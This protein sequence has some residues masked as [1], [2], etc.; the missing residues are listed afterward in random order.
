MANSARVVFRDDESV[1]A[2]IYYADH[3]DKF[4]SGG[5]ED[6][7]VATACF[8]IAMSSHHHQGYGTY[9][10][11]DPRPQAP[12]HLHKLPKGHGPASS[13]T[14]ITTVN[15]LSSLAHAPAFV[16]A[17]GR[18]DELGRSVSDG[19][20]ADVVGG[21]MEG[22]GVKEGEALTFWKGLQLQGKSKLG[23]PTDIRPPNAVASSSTL[24]ALTT[25]A[26][27][28]TR[29]VVVPREQWFIRRALLAKDAKERER[30]ASGDL[31]PGSTDTT[32]SS[33]PIPR[34]TTP[35]LASLLSI[36]LPPPPRAT[37]SVEGYQPPAYFHLRENNRGWQVLKNIGWD[38]QGGLGRGAGA[39]VA[40][41]KGDEVKQEEGPAERPGLVETSSGRT[42]KGKSRES[43]IDL[44]LDSASSGS[45]SDSDSNPTSNSQRTPEKFGEAFITPAQ[46]SS[47]SSHPLIWSGRTAPIA[48]YLKT[49]LRGI[50]AL[51]ATDRRR[52]LLRPSTLA[53][54]PDHP[55]KR[56]RVTHSA[57]EIRESVRDSKAAGAGLVGEERA[58]WE[59]QKVK[60]DVEVDRRERQRW[61][62]IINRE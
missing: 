26:P 21:A 59:R 35:S 10:D 44:T 17:A 30:Q 49:D 54:P 47:T 40:E 62:E 20:Q 22:S 28:S 48:T 52:T 33:T 57:E 34:P 12:L 39:D 50:G 61:R 24:P 32:S 42:G 58:M 19:V 31:T 9:A 11:T 36:D 14:R 37:D 4:R 2:C 3:R 56:K 25:P 15:P 53:A 16:P 55:S 38:G 29:N 43:A 13:S 45:D 60:R 6:T 46:P 1:H 41:R 7:V 51:S 5:Y 18:Y 8:L 27:I 23:T